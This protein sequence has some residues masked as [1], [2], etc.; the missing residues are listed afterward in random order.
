M[1]LRDPFLTRFVFF[2]FGSK[3]RAIEII[4]EQI[5]LYEK[6]LKKRQDNLVRWQ[7]QDIYV[8]LI[9]DLGVRLNEVFLS[10]LKHAYYEISK[11][12]EKADDE[13]AQQAVGGST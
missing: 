7:K 6:Y 13:Q 3:K 10:W 9:A 5:K 8:R 4:G 2:G 11:D 12:M 1:L